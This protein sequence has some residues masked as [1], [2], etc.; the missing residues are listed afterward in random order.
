MLYK[1]ESDVHGYGLFSDTPIYKGEL[2]GKFSILPAVYNTKFSIWFDDDHFRAT[3]IL[4]YS[5][6]SSN[7]NAEVN[8]DT[9]ELIAISDIPAHSEIFWH[10]GSEFEE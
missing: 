3:N 10:Y 8:G 4:K 1:A 2:V 9:L 5:N 7:P 6:H